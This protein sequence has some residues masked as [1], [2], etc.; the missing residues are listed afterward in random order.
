[1]LEKAGE[2]PRCGEIKRWLYDA[3]ICAACDY[4][5]AMPATKHRDRALDR[6][7]GAVMQCEVVMQW[8]IERKI[9]PRCSH[10]ATRIVDG[11]FLCTFHA[12]RAL[13]EA[14][15][16]QPPSTVSVRSTSALKTQR[17]DDGQ[18]G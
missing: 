4:G 11:K 7:G 13:A 6:E 14:I 2:C 15:G 1:M 12:K 5:N 9:N 17:N 10:K 16:R 8:A 3:Q 18:Q